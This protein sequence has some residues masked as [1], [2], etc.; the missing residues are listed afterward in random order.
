MALW[1]SPARQCKPATA[2]GQCVHGVDS[3]WSGVCAWFCVSWSVLPFSDLYPRDESVGCGACPGHLHWD[4]IDA[5]R[6]Q[7]L[8]G[9]SLKNLTVE[10]YGVRT[11]IAVN[12]WCVLICVAFIVKIYL[13]VQ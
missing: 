5:G 6:V 4:A 13:V 7:Y 11:D 1:I 10:E 12:C 8:G 2:R 3:E 9:L